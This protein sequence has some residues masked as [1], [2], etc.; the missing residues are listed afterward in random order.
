MKPR[1]SFVIP[2]YN[3]EAYLRETL[4]SCLDQ[5]VRQL[6]VIVVDDAST[7]G[8]GELIQYYAKKDSRIKPIR[9]SEN[10]GSANARNIGNSAAQGDYIFVLDG[11]DKATRNRVKDTLTCFEVKKADL[12]YGGFIT[13]DTFGNME[14]RFSP[15]PFTREAS[16]KYKTHQIC[17]STVAY[18]KGLTMNVQY[19]PEHAQWAMEDFSFIWNAHAKGYRFAYV[20]NPFCYYRIMD[21]SQSKRRN[22]KETI[23]VK[24]E[25]VSA[26]KI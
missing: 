5:S 25:F 7:D 15:H 2:V 22:E 23:K 20:K 4:D 3:G 12:V 26:L 16:L 6:E 9:L 21:N 11:D 24:D 8:T 10:G 1:A 13:I 18:R 17:H 19:I 14:R